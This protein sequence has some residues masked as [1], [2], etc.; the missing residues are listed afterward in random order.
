MIV[1]EE[2]EHRLRAALSPAELQVQD[3][4]AAHAGHA[5]ARAEGQTHFAVRAVSDRFEGLSRLA[6]QR[7]VHE[8]VADLMGRPIHALSLTTLTP[9]EA[10]A[11]RA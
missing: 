4:S 8:T 2:I 5:G 11:R 10:E 1:A 7:L 3:V 9:G 6:R